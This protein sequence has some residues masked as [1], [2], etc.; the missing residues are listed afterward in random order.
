MRTIGSAS[1]A[2]NEIS[3]SIFSCV[4]ASER[5]RNACTSSRSRDGGGGGGITRSLA[6][7]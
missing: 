1:T 6:R 7:L 2:R 4:D 5:A 3:T